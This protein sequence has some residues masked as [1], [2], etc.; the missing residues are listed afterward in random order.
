MKKIIFITL[1]LL[2]LFTVTINIPFIEKSKIN[3][4]ND[5]LVYYLESFG[6]GTFH[7]KIFN[8]GSIKVLEYRTGKYKLI[9]TL[10]N[11]KLEQL[12]NSINNNEFT[13][14]KNS[15]WKKYRIRYPGCVDCYMA[16]DIFINKNGKT[17]LISENK[18]VFEIIKE[19][20]TKGIKL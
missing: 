3:L 1:I 13:I 9:D 4:E 11:D 20:K 14:K 16:T 8:D 7:I 2:I 6:E 18:I 10:S 19:L 5:A 15:L 12:K 17:I